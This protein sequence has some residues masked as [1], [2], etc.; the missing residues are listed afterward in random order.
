MTCSGEGRRSA[1]GWGPDP[2]KTSDSGKFGAWV[3]NSAG[4]L[5]FEQSS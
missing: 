3:W 4:D 2:A 5:I 1:A